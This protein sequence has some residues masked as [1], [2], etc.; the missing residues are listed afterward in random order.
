MKRFVLIGAMLLAFTVPAM[1]GADYNVCFNSIDGDYDGE[2]TT[3]EFDT[4]FPGG[5]A[6]VFQTA[7]ADKSGSVSHEEWEDYKQSQGFE[8]GE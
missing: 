8:E 3:A 2:L 5:D 7:D 4:A 6:A 1:A